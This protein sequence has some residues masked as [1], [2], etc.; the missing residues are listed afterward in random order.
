[1]KI[2]ISIIIIFLLI[3]C[4]KAEEQTTVKISCSR[5]FP[6]RLNGKD[7]GRCGSML[8]LRVSQGGVIEIVPD[9]RAVTPDG[10]PTNTTSEGTAK[11]SYNGTEV[12]KHIFGNGIQYIINW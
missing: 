7:V 12:T 3:S 8:Q 2:I 1:M 9:I 11:I 10:R 4:K 5:D 6:V